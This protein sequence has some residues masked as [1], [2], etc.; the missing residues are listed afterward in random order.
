MA[1]P[2]CLL[3]RLAPRQ[4]CRTF[5]RA[6]PHCNRPVSFWRLWSAFRW[7]PYCCPHCD[8]L[9]EI[10]LLS[11]LWCCLAGAMPMMVIGFLLLV[12][13]HPRSRWEALPMVAPI[14]LA[15]SLFMGLLLALFG[16]FRPVGPLRR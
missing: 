12:H 9:S 11:R 3:T 6:C 8:G 16:R 15:G 4:S 1:A 2:V 10:G 14:G 13:L 7:T 5:M